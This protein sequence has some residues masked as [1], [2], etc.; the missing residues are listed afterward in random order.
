ML[1]SKEADFVPE[2]LILKFRVVVAADVGVIEGVVVQTGQRSFV[3]GVWAQNWPRITGTISS[4]DS[5]WRLLG[6]TD[7]EST[8]TGLRVGSNLRQKKP[9]KIM[10]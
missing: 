2:V 10:D 5:R 4:L 3:S 8:N 7:R 6:T 1:F 9:N